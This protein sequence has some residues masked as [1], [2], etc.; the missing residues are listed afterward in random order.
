M[1]PTVP[2]VTVV[3]PHEVRKY[4]EAME[5]QAEAEELE[6]IAQANRD[7]NKPAPEVGHV[8]HVTTARGIKR[9]ARSG[10][11][12][13]DKLRRAVE[14][15]DAS[16][17][18]VARMQ[19]SGRS[20]TNVAGAERILFDDALIVHHQGHSGDNA[21][22]MRRA[23][24]AESA[25]AA[26]EAREADARAELEKYKA[27]LAELERTAGRG[28]QPD[29]M[30]PTRLQARAQARAAAGPAPAT[31]TPDDKAK[32]EGGDFGGGSQ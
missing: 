3:H 25:K 29:G 20:V 18:E 2:V 10:L 9:R 5:R 32:G 8:L 6:R 17:A 12:Y 22:L 19:A 1:M 4:N 14:V 21:E 31:P 28:A 30:A 11:Q 27:R 24:A 16:D 26:A 7:A 13:E 15:V 23:E